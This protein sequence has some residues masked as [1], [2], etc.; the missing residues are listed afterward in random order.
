MN[1]RRI[2]HLTVILC[3]MVCCSFTASVKSQDVQELSTC[4]RTFDGSTT[5]RLSTSLVR[6]VAPGTYAVYYQLQGGRMFLAAGLD[7]NCL[8][9]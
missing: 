9:E 3:L 4:N 6:K 8:G 1:S 5:C 2:I 7:P